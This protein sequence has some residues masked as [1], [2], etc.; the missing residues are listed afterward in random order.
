MS[1][2][3]ERWAKESREFIERQKKRTRTAF[4]A[5]KREHRD[6]GDKPDREGPGKG[7]E[8]SDNPVTDS[9]FL[10]IPAFDGD[11]G[12]RPV[13]AGIP[14][15]HS[16]AVNVIHESLDP[17]TSLEDLQGSFSP[18]L[19]A[20]TTYLFEAWVHNLGDMF[21]PAVNVEFFLRTPGMG[22][23]AESARLLGATVISIP[24]N[25]RARATISF[26]ATMDDVGHHCLLV[27]ASSFNPPD[28]PT[29]WSALVARNDR[30]IGQQNLN[31]VAGGSQMMM[32]MSAPRRGRRK[33]AKVRV[34]INAAPVP[35]HLK[36]DACLNEKLKLGKGLARA[37][38][39]LSAEVP[40][41]KTP[42]TENSWDL[43]V[44]RGET[45]RFMVKFPETKKGATA[46]TYN[47]EAFDIETK[48]VFD[49]VTG[50]R[51]TA[52]TG[53]TTHP[54]IQVL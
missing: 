21:A 47:V 28:A 33:A 10:V 14:T 17:T 36:R 15:W 48:T 40:F 19:T 2:K 52:Q 35:A 43:E 13:A 41:R 45:H 18:S 37:V 50:P 27:R 31:V 8:Y 5:Y 51:I 34:R 25:D 23:T 39:G 49:G 46:R 16:P 1:E 20:G 30:H 53:S 32:L 4:K 26:D 6:G 12:T 24:R 3:W 42:R 29:D 44:R 54:V 11:D 22:A 9:T 38:F 7:P